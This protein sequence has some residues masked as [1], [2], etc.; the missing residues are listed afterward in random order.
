[1]YKAALKVQAVYKLWKKRASQRALERTGT[2]ALA[3]GG[4]L[5]SPSKPLLSSPSDR[6]SSAAVRGLLAALALRSSSP[7]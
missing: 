1:M 5:P 6:P 4:P 3:G 2:S 7:A